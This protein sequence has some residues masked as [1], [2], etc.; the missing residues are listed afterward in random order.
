MQ[1]VPPYSAVLIQIYVGLSCRA[2]KLRR[3]LRVALGDG[4]Q[5]VLLRAMRAHS[6]FA[7]YVPLSLLLL[8]FLESAVTNPWYLHALCSIL[9][10]GRLLHAR[11]VG[12]RQNHQVT[13]LREWLLHSFRW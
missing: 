3:N 7:E 6:N 4:G 11:G 10:A 8:H 2:I 5:E 12:K 1:I 9:I 13:E